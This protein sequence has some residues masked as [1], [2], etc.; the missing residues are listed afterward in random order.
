M[1]FCVKRAKLYTTLVYVPVKCTDSVT[2]RQQEC[3]SRLPTFSVR[4]LPLYN[5]A[6]VIIII[7]NQKTR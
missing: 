1:Q 5:A 3:Q 7:D 2:A 6:N 4:T